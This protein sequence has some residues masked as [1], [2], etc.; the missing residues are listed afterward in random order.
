MSKY[1]VSVVITTF[2]PGDGKRTEIASETLTSF[3]KNLIYPNLRYIIS[4]NNSPK[5]DEHIRVITQPL[6]NNN[7]EFEVLNV[8]GGNVGKSKNEA[9]KKAFET[10]EIVLLSEDDWAFKSPFYLEK[11]VQLMLDFDTVD[12]VRF[13]YLGSTFTASYEDFGLFRTFWNLHRGSGVYIYSGQIS[14][15]HRRFYTK[16]GWH[17]EGVSP[18]EEE[19]EF[20]QRF[21]GTEGVGKILWDADYG[22]TLNAGP[23]VNLGMGNSLNGVNS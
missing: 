13:G 21:N 5:H 18:G 3:A 12:M 20:C 9:L 11:Y 8:V 7:I 4:D 23:C 16:T 17:K 2:D 10:S 6:V 22:C 14:L 1:P 15:R 19:I